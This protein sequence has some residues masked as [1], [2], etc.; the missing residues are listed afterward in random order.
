MKF[1][2]YESFN[3]GSGEHK[4]NRSVLERVFGSETNDKINQMESME[5]TIIVNGNL[6][7]WAEE[8][9]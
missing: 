1:D 3:D 4:I 8:K 2:Y 7:Y 6:R 9:I 5:A